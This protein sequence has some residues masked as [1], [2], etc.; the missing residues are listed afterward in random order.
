LNANRKLIYGIVT[1]GS[2]AKGL[3]KIATPGTSIFAVVDSVYETGPASRSAPLI[4]LLKPIV[5][6]AS[7][8]SGLE[9]PLLPLMLVEALDDAAVDLLPFSDTTSS[10]ILEMILEVAFIQYLGV[11]LAHGL[12]ARRAASSDPG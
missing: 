12:Y 3:Q 7:G 9:F 8:Y 1:R 4:P 11:S 2:L 10:K 6:L 5:D